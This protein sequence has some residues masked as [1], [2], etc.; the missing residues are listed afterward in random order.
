M[1]NYAG[2]EYPDKFVSDIKDM[3]KEKHWAIIEYGSIHIPGDQRSIDCPGHGYPA[4]S[5]S[6]IKYEAYFTKEKWLK[7]IEYR[8]SNNNFNSYSRRDYTAL[9]VNPVKINKNISVEV[10]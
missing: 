2:F 1:N 5:E 3:P 6:T 10:A 7:Q 8:E 4:H 9:E